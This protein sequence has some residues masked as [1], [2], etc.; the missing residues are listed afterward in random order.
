MINPW[1]DIAPYKTSD[2]ANFKGRDEDIRK[3]SK[4][5]RQNDFSVLYAESGIG[6][7]S[8]INAGIMPAFIDTDYYFIRVEFPLEVLAVTDGNSSEKLVENLESWLCHKIFPNVSNE[9]NL[10]KGELFQELREFT[11]VARELEHN[12]WW[13]LHAY[14]YK[15]EGRI[16]KP[17]IV[18]DQFE[19]VFQKANPALLYEL[20]AILDSLSSRIPPRVVL[21]RLY[22]LEEKGIYV[23]LDSS[24]DFKVLF[25]LRKEYLAE[26]DYWTND[27][28]SNSQLLQSRMILLPFTKVQAEEV[29]TQQRIEGEFV[30]TLVDIKDDILNLFEQRFTNSTIKFRNKYSYEAFLLSIVCS[31]LYVIAVNSHKDRLTKEDMQNINLN[32]LILTFYN[33]SLGDFIPKRHLKIIEDELVDNSGERNRIK[34]TTDKLNALKFQEC[35][36][37]ELK[38]RHIVKS[39]DGYVELIHDRVAEAVFYKR[40]ENN[41]KQWF[42]LQ[43]IVL[44]FII[45]LF[46]VI[47]FNWGWSTSLNTS[48]LSREY[49]KREFKLPTDNN[50]FRKL[51]VEA[52]I[53][54]N[55]LLNRIGIHDYYN[56]RSIE[57]QGRKPISTSLYISDCPNLET[58]SISDSITEISGGLDRCSNLHFIRLPQN[59]KTI[60]RHVFSGVDSLEFEVPESASNKFAWKNGILW[61]LKNRKIIYAQ[62]NADS[63]MI[64]PKE[65]E[66][67]DSL[68][69]EYGSNKRIIRNA[70]NEKPQILIDGDTIVKVNMYNNTA[71]DFSDTIYNNIRYIGDK[72]FYNCWNLREIILPCNL[73]SIG[74][75]AFANCKSLRCINFPSSLRKIHHEAFLGCTN[76]SEILLP[77]SLNYLG[78]YAFSGCSRLKKVHLPDSVNME[79]VNDIIYTQFEGCDSL[80][81]LSF[82][83][84]SVFKESGGILFHEKR[85]CLFVGQNI[86]YEDSLI[87]IN[88][89]I[90]TF[91]FERTFDLKNGGKSTIICSR[92]VHVMNKKHHV[93]FLYG[94]GLSCSLEPVVYNPDSVEYLSLVKGNVL[95]VDCH[96]MYELH[97]ANTSPGSMN[98]DLPETVKSKITLY[99]PYG[100]KKYFNSPD[101]TLFKEIK[102]D[103]CLLRIKNMLHEML[104]NSL[105]QS[106]TLYV[107]CFAIVLMVF[108]FVYM[109]YR[110]RYIKKHSKENVNIIV[111]NCKGILVAFSTLFVFI[112]TWMSIYWTLFFAF[113]NSYAMLIGH[114]IGLTGAYFSTWVLVYSRNADIWMTIKMGIRQLIAK[115]KTLTFVE[116]KDFFILR[117]K[118]V[119]LAIIQIVKNRY[120]Y[121]LSVLLVCILI[122]GF[123]YKRDSWSAAI[124]KAEW[125]LL[126]N[127]WDKENKE[128]VES[129]LYSS[130]PSWKF[131]LSEQQECDL[132]AI[133]EKI[134]YGIPNTKVITEFSERGHNGHVT[135]VAFSHNDSL[136]VTG[137]Y[138]DTAII[139]NALT[140]DTIR[141]LR[142]HNGHVTSVAFSHNDSL[143]VT[144]SYDD[145]AIIWNAS[146]G[147]AIRTLRGYKNDVNSVAF[148]HND[149]LIVTGF[150]NNTAFI[151]D[152]LTGDTIRTLRGHKGCVNSVAFSHNDSLIVTSSDDNTAIIWD[153]LT[154]D[155][156]RPL[157]RNYRDIEYVAFSHNDSLIVTGSYF[158]TAIV[159]DALTGDIIRVLKGDHNHIR[160]VSFNRSGDKILVGTDNDVSIVDYKSLAKKR[161]ETKVK[162]LNGETK[163]VTS[164][165]NQ[166]ICIISNDTAIIWNAD[167]G[168]TTHALK[169][170]IDRIRIAAYSHEGNL[171]AFGLSN[172]RIAVWNVLTD[173]VIFSKYRHGNDIETLAFSHAGNYIMTGSSD[174][175]VLIW[176]ALTGDTIRSLRGH[177]GHV[178][179]VAFS[180]DDK[181]IVAGSSDRTAIIWNA[182]SGDSICSWKPK[183]SDEIKFVSFTSDNSNVVLGCGYSVFFWDNWK[184]GRPNMVKDFTLKSS[185][186]QF[187]YDSRFVLDEYNNVYDTN[188]GNLLYKIHCQDEGETYFATDKD[189]YY[190]L[191]DKRVQKV[192][193]MSLNEWIEICHK[194]LNKE[195]NKN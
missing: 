92:D 103:S 50:N 133:Y 23:S 127:Y 86:N 104:S 111:L 46:S 154:G 21:D 27:V 44:S 99:V 118:K 98:L 91:S 122:G 148:S 108:F 89:N 181:Y 59:I 129:L 167:K 156:I 165:N 68:S 81:N 17:F 74:E 124:E 142:G 73:D 56:L 45:L 140:G 32:E 116:I 152:A 143:I 176:D 171:V 135:S 166:N 164:Y 121:I 61:D 12:L 20:F 119:F 28:Y 159:W 95:F 87:E 90:V 141:T 102:E 139:W 53:L 5:L 14:K 63:I 80:N 115:C 37:A 96:K 9:E 162:L 15:V 29:I 191:S 2:A 41:K 175:T 57:V 8:F 146:S 179:S 188:S 138:D 22:E 55:D 153:A 157:K 155:I 18:F 52:L 10:I 39:S 48:Y 88:D 54:E 6:K 109:L 82:S 182:S 163:I 131:L 144:G 170:R 31:R 76:I 177:K 35:Y 16:V 83:E 49:T 70:K 38:K 172:N 128:N 194:T 71:I 33:E 183:S 97:I 186:K 161:I 184:V 178:T 174:S 114:I 7:T 19:E 117:L 125:M 26:F 147:D 1:K 137:S 84:K 185:I 132:K 3:F 190:I 101:Y 4:L 126:K 110:K 65:L 169:E 79:V 193:L 195:S 36:L 107:L 106:K 78:L 30:N 66:E 134:G 100:C 72:A 75:A 60:Q 130:L 43:R 51:H 40:K 93:A 24:I 64:F 173:E 145:T 192:K 47:A 42:L 69:I 25:S 168:K 113:E 158:D 77:D 150:L 105:S 136:I 11:E 189:E 94:K 13:K 67:V 34:I 85:P 151:W 149:S 58:L 120:K 112:L 123:L 187:G 160:S 180:Y 62:K